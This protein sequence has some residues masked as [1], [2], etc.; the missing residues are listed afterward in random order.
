MGEPTLAE[1][2]SKNEIAFQRIQELLRVL[3]KSKMLHILYALGIG[4][5]GLRFS[6]LKKSSLADSTTLT[7]RLT[8]LEEIGMITRKELS[9]TPPAVEYHFTESYG[10]LKPVLE[11]LLHYGLE[12][13]TNKS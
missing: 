3:S 13:V 1:W 11:G 7:R 6:E 2:E 5:G 8:E 12:G 9:T 10:I 4:D